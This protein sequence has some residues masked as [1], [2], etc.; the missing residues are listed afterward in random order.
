MEST[1]KYFAYGT[2]LDVEHM[3]HYCPTA[4][5]V[6]LMRLSGY[7]LDFAKCPG[8]ERGGCTLRPVEGA[9][10]WGIQY[11]MSASDHHQLEEISGIPTGDWARQPVVVQDE[12][13][14]SIETST[15]I[16]PNSPGPFAPPDSYVAPILRGAVEN[17]LPAEYVA[18]LRELISDAQERGN[19]P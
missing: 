11:E 17:H 13:G 19:S 12:N 15:F 5:P 6:G 7:E 10:L 16:V 9:E 2:L 18:R 14:A 8:G 4:T 3:R 1:G